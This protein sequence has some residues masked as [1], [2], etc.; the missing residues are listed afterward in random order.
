MLN[1]LIM[2]L[3]MA[4]SFFS[5]S[6]IAEEENFDTLAKTEVLL[7]GN[8]VDGTVSFI[9]T[10]TFENL[11][12]VDI[13]PDRN[14]MNFF[15]YANPVRAVAYNVVKYKQLLHHFEPG[16]GNRFVDDIF[17]SPNGRTLY[18]SRANL[19]DVAAFDLTKPDH[20]MIWRR[21]VAGFLKRI[22]QLFLLMVKGW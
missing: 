6:A 4:F 7:V 9:D 2:N 16:G 21:F 12:I 5:M 11:G 18:V 22:M 1:I 14:R 20:P 3:I 15:I 19:G 10:N 8:S 17:L 13:Y